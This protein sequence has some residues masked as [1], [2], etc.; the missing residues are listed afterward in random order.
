MEHWEEKH[1]SMVNLREQRRKE[2]KNRCYY[3]KKQFTYSPQRSV[4]LEH[5]MRLADGGS[6]DPS[7]LVAACYECNAH[8]GDYSPEVW[9]AICIDVIRLKKSRKQEIGRIKNVVK[10]RGWNHID[11][12]PLNRYHSYIRKNIFVPRINEKYRLLIEEVIQSFLHQQQK[13]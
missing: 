10:R 12:M 2:Q 4:T 9:A 11:H 13:G 5:L 1:I 7:N 6:D 3:C 8:R